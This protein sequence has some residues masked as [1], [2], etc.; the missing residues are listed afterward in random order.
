MPANLY[1]PLFLTWLLLN[2]VLFGLNATGW[3]LATLSMHLLATALVFVIARKLLLDHW[4]AL[5]AAALFGLHPVHV[6]AVA[7]VSGVTEPLAGVLFLSAFTCYLK[8]REVGGGKLW[9]LP[10]LIAFAAAML[11]KETA[12]ALP[13]IIVAYE[14]CSPK[15][16][17]TSKRWRA[18]VPVIAPYAALVGAYL[19]ARVIVLHGFAH[20]ISAL[21]PWLSALSWPWLTQFYLGILLF[22]VGLGP[23]YDVEYVP[24]F[25]FG[26]LVVPLFLLALLGWA[27]WH[28][29][30]RIGSRLPLFIGLVFALTLSP[31]LVSFT[32]MSRWEGAH[33]RYVY[34]PSFAVA[35]LAAY[36]MR[37]LADRVGV[38][39]MHALAMC[40]VVALGISTWH[41][42][43]YWRDD[44]ALFRRGVAVAPRNLMA[45]LNLAAEL[46]R[47][48]DFGQAFDLSKEA[49]LLDPESG[50]AL[51]MA[52]EAAFF[53][54]NYTDSEK[55]YLAALR[56]E[57]PQVEQLYYLAI[58]R[59][60]MA[61]YADALLVM[62]RAVQLWPSAPRLHYALGLALAGTGNLM[63]ARNALRTELRMVPDSPGIEADLARIEDILGQQPT[64]TPAK[65]LQSH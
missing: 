61:R 17:D 2:R 46:S 59:I 35:V 45:K 62:R 26:R 22:P 57:P 10:S 20:R 21:P 38:R 8:Y 31:V 58:A 43:R 11:V 34:L 25:S 23:F 19:V 55:Y 37:S 42:T 13:A 63:E 49:V 39:L 1:R 48:H 64:A 18:L 15:S 5:F 30:R 3:H 50:L 4:A 24:S 56:L 41:Q 44:L 51:R 6:E 36:G 52:G 60:R 29:S 7:W 27:L 9:L 47:R 40:V 12:T 54:G 14:F 33:D 53:S 16:E 65:A 32:I 28:W